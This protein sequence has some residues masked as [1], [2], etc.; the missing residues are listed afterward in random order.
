[1]SF[2]KKVK[3]FTGQTAKIISVQ[4]TMTH[5][6]MLSFLATS[7]SDMLSLYAG[8]MM[9]FPNKVENSCGRW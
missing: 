5:I 7:L 1:M 6:C 8:G 2:P 3:V 9:L 4:S